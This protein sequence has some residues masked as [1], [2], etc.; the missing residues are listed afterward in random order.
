MDIQLDREDVI[1][2][3][4][5]AN[6]RLL[7][8]E[9]LSGITRLEKLVYLL[10]AETDFEGIASFFAFI[11]HNFGPF[12]KEV[13]E[14]VE[15]LQSCDLINVGEKT[16]VSYYANLGEAHLLSEI[17]ENRL[18]SEEPENEE[19]ES[20]AAAGMGATEK[21]FSLTADGRKVAR[22]MRNAVGSRR[23]G[24]IQAVDELILRFG[25]MP[26]GQIIRYVYRRHPG[27]TV[28]SIH[29]EARRC[30]GQGRG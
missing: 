17:S 30:L 13:Y 7:G 2:L 25:N 6:E 18:D 14:A 19:T 11:P 10:T 28:K 16:Y 15:F 22:I 20:D 5:E 23:P 9:I 1:L 8:K 24:D 21:M 12:A 4:L 27:M 29:P 26:L 3:F